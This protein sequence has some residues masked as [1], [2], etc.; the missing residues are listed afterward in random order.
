MRTYKLKIAYDGGRY[1]GWQRQPT[2]DLTVQ[3]Q[4]ENAL[5]GGIGYPVDIHAA[6]RT[7]A[8]VHAYGQ[9][10]HM[11]VAGK[12]DEATLCKK[13]NEVLPDDIRILDMELVKNGFHSRYQAKGKRYR[14]CIDLRKERPDVFTRKYRFHY[15][16]ILNLEAMKEASGYLKGKHD[17]SAFT[18][19]K[20]DEKST[21]KYIYDIIFDLQKDE[22]FITFY[23][24]GFLYHMVRILTGTL[25]EVG[26]GQRSPESVRHALESG[27]REDAGFLAPASG[28]FLM[29]VIYEI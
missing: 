29:E 23:G 26:V 20:E 28:L 5:S 9:V 25:L 15:P 6:G 4:L 19:R 2:T 3:S 12:L 27:V 10:A 18:D 8:G 22:L 24:T 11:K 13:V 1:Q 14:Y 17:F 16:E 7:D 21:V